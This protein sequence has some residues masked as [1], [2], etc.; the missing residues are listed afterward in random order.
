MTQRA[1]RHCSTS[2]IPIWVKDPYVTNSLRVQCEE[3][4]QLINVLEHVIEERE[5][6]FE[7]Y[8]SNAKALFCTIT[9]KGSVLPHDTMVTDISGITSNEPLM[10]N[11]ED[12]CKFR[13]I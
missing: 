1:K 7:H 3:D 6:Y 11:V 13:F 9:H 2:T 4:Y 10:I 5:G 8:S 12:E